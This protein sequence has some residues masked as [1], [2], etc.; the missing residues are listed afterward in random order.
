MIGSMKQLQLELW[1][2]PQ[3]Y[4]MIKKGKVPNMKVEIG[5]V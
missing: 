1:Y 4:R 2:T 3:G 5:E